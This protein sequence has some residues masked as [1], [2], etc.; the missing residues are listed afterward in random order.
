MRIAQQQ[1]RPPS[2]V[3]RS[4]SYISSWLK[5]DMYRTKEEKQGPK[6]LGLPVPPADVLARPRGPVETPLPKP[7]EKAIPHKELVD[8]DHVDLP[9]ETKPQQ[10]QEPRRL[11]EL[12]HVPTPAPKTVKYVSRRS[13]TSSVKDLVREF[14][15]KERA[16]EQALPPRVK[17]LRKQ[18][19]L[20]AKKAKPAWRY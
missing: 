14:E 6:H 10:K 19:T 18:E 2:A 7:L 1:Q 9:P 17:E 5:P 4:L 3:K 15:A 8:L 13:S 16:K 12:S 20:E 11:V